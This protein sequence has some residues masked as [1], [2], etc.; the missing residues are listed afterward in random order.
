MGIRRARAVVAGTVLVA[1]MLLGAALA[2]AGA[3]RRSTG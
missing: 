2:P 3:S 1:S